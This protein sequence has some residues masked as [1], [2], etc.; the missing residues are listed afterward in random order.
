VRTSKEV[1]AALDYLGLEPAH[2]EALEEQLEGLVEW[3]K[4]DRLEAVEELFVEYLMDAA[5]G[6]DFG[7]RH[8]A[9]RSSQRSVRK[10]A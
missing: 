5:E 2:R 1:F 7:N 8:P 9:R 6:W 4:V 3:Q 10:L